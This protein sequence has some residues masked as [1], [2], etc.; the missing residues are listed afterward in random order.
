MQII[1]SFQKALLERFGFEEFCSNARDHVIAWSRQDVKESNE[2]F[3][4][5]D[6]R[7]VSRTF[8]SSLIQTP[9]H[10]IPL[11][12]SNEHQRSSHPKQSDTS[13]LQRAAK[14]GEVK[15]PRQWFLWSISLVYV[16]AF[17]SIYVQIPGTFLCFFCRGVFGGYGGF[18]VRHEWMVALTIV[19]WNVDESKTVPLVHSFINASRSLSCKIVSRG[20]TLAFQLKLSR[21]LVH[22]PNFHWSRICAVDLM[23]KWYFLDE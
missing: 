13:S 14:M 20:M 23:F 7:K 17:A 1:F 18:W 16:C 8:S 4:R 22:K 6:S 2:L 5:T 3:K 19:L 9:P 15:T 12:F 10:P 21:D 11:H